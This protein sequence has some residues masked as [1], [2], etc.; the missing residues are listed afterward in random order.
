MKHCDHN[1]TYK[2]T[3]YKNI[4]LRSAKPVTGARLIAKS[5]ASN[6]LT[7]RLQILTQKFFEKESIESRFVFVLVAADSFTMS[8]GLSSTHS[9]NISSLLDEF[10]DIMPDV[11]PPLRDIHYAIDIISGSQLPNLPHH[12]MNLVERVEWNRKFEGILKKDF[13]HCSHI[14]C[15]VP[16]LLTLK[17][18]DLGE[19]IR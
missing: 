10:R 11:M 3:H 8:F 2:F 16:I 1:N 18:M 5:S 7:Q 17:K 14:F 6:I 15:V 4:L 12:R 19:C 13:I 9:P